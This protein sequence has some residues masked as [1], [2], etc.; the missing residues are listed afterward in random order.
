MPTRWADNDVYGHVNNSVY[1]F[2]CDTL[3][4]EWL[5]NQG[6]LEIGK[7]ET[8][9]LVVETSCN[10]FA[11]ITYPD[12]IHGGLRITKIGS[13]SVRYEIGLFKNDED[14][15]SAKGHF[16]HVYVDEETR[17]PVKLTDAMRANFD[18]ISG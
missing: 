8:V 5:I 4:N 14:E 13:S 17:R 9:G 18:S 3:V 16:V 7:S 10:F 12:V 1:Y 6:L 2:F 15:C 11:P